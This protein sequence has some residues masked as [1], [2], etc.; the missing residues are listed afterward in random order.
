MDM[1]RLRPAE[2]RR[3]EVVGLCARIDGQRRRSPRGT[4][5]RAAYADQLDRALE[6]LH[7]AVE[8]DERDAAP[9]PRT[10]DTIHDV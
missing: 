1:T 8:Q 2:R 7:H 10:R 3:L 9:L 5:R 6:V 4:F